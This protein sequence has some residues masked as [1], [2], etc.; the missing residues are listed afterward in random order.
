MGKGPRNRRTVQESGHGDLGAV[1]VDVEIALYGD[2]GRGTG[3]DRSPKQR[4]NSRV[5]TVCGVTT[6]GGTNGCI[7]GGQLGSSHA[8]GDRSEGRGI[9]D[10]GDVSGGE[11][12]IALTDAGEAGFF[13][14]GVFVGEEKEG[15]VFFESAAESRAGL[16]ASVGL[17][18]GN[19]IAG[20]V[21]LTGERVARLERFVAEVAE[22]VPV[23]IVGAAL[24][25]DVDDTAGGTAIFRVVIA[26]DHLKFLDGFLRDAGGD[27]VDGVVDGVGAIHPD[28]IG[29]SAGAAHAEAA[30]RRGAA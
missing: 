25:N 13:A 9:G 5:R 27:A 17:L 23:E 8:E 20:R 16:N 21:D 15:F 6:D 29:S 1:D 26:E 4:L 14:L 18:G 28:H 12:E 7:V 3:S 24:G 19:Q 22:D 10:A 30:V 11:A 2:V